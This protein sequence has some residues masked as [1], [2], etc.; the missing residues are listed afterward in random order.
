MSKKYIH[1]R[2]ISAI[3]ELSNIEDKI[4]NLNEETDDI[5]KL[6]KND[7]LSMLQSF[8]F[9]Y[10][11]NEYSNYH[12]VY[13]DNTYSKN[14]GSLTSDKR[15]IPSSVHLKAKIKRNQDNFQGK[16]IRY[17]NTEGGL[18]AS[19]QLKLKKR[20]LGEEHIDEEPQLLHR[21]DKTQGSYDLSA[22]SFNPR[23]RPNIQHRSGTI[24]I[25]NQL[26]NATGLSSGEV[27]KQKIYQN[28]ILGP[29]SASLPKSLNSSQI[30]VKNKIKNINAHNK[31]TKGTTKKK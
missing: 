20:G 19:Q 27:L 13:A 24:T 10:D 11:V 15:V 3:A 26:K 7:F 21:I 16:L 29:P 25:D 30:I 17:K 6:L 4:L 9:I 22:Y 14:Y 12:T 28:E 31:N 23:L 18:T 8:P 2:D 5:S 1:N